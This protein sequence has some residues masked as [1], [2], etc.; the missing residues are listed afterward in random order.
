V[1]V[2]VTNGEED[3]GDTLM[4]EAK[5]R[6]QYTDNARHERAEKEANER[7]T[8][9]TLPPV[10]STPLPQGDIVREYSITVYEEP[11]E[12][13]EVKPTIPD[14][15]SNYGDVSCIS[16]QETLHVLHDRNLAKSLPKVG[17]VVRFRIVM[18]PGSSWLSDECV[19]KLAD[20]A[21]CKL[22]RA[23]NGEA[24]PGMVSYKDITV[25]RRPAKHHQATGIS[26]GPWTSAV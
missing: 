25:M 12:V 16:S 6:A 24:I 3:G 10:K 17:D 11:K 18:L 20:G 15:G 19:V 9:D 5:L 26:E 13:K 7:D 1:F 8:A 22:A 23:D 4:R 14:M 21:R 2:L